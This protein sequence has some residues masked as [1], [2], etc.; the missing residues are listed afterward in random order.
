M[1]EQLLDHPHV[2]ASGQQMGGEGVAQRVRGDVL[3]QAGA[4]P[5]ARNIPR[6]RVSET[7][8]QGEVRL[9]KDDGRLPM[10]DHNARIFVV[11]DDGPAA[12]F[13]AEALAREAFHNV[14]YYEGAFAQ[15]AAPA[16]AR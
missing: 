13:V 7:K 15:G 9:A 5:G 3:P 12:R 4:L 10:E 1:P 6:S 2:G 14:A 11:G 16:P 8:D